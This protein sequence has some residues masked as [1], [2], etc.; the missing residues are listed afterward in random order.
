[1]GGWSEVQIGSSRG[2]QRGNITLFFTFNKNV[3]SPR[4]SNCLTMLGLSRVSFVIRSHFVPLLI[5]YA[6]VRNSYYFY[7]DCIRFLKDFASALNTSFF[8]CY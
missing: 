1:M 2:E 5:S 4:V 3:C 6:R 8:I 7:I